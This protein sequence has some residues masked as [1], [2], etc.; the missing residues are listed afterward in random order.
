MQSGAGVRLDGSITAADIVV[1]LRSRHGIKVN[2]ATVQDLIFRQLAGSTVETDPPVLDLCQLVSLLLIPNIVEAS[3][4][5]TLG[6]K[7]IEPLLTILQS[8]QKDPSEKLDRDVLRKV[9][10][11]HDGFFDI[12]DDVLDDMLAV[13][14]SSVL[15]ALSSDLGG[16]DLT[17]KDQ[18]TTNMEDAL[19]VQKASNLDPENSSASI[20]KETMDCPFQKIHTAS[21]IDFCAETYRRPLYVVCLFACAIIN[22]FAYVYATNDG[23]W[24]DIECGAMSDVVCGI[25]QGLLTWLAIMIQLTVLGIIFIGFGSLGNRTY[26]KK[27][28]L[29]ACSLLISIVVIILTAIIPFF[30]VRSPFKMFYCM[31]TSFPIIT[32][33]VA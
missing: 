33:F 6:S 32:G 5:K 26:H 4:D 17:W 3:H 18:L 7:M 23:S 28:W 31:K 14:D 13:A 1:Y 20:L 21:F 11:L 22:Y 2:E 27:S 24:A 30:V 15:D 8:Y 19:Q 10:A 25:I 9:F 12:S 16:F 29:T